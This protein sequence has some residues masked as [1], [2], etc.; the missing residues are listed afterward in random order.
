MAVP[1]SQ[2]HWPIAVGRTVVLADGGRANVR[3]LDRGDVG[4]VYAVFDGLS[5]SSRRQRFAGAKPSLSAREAERLAAV[6]H[7]NHE[8]FVAA[9]PTTRRPVAEA[10]LVRDPA[11]L[12]AGE[13]AFAVADDWQGRGLGT[14][15]AEIL[16]RRARELGITRLRASMLAEN[17]RSLALMRR[18]GPVV[19]RRYAAGELEVEVALD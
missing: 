10:H 8:A 6:D 12:A 17:A 19:A 11:D 4:S 15:L 1:G 16:A 14:R 5:A 7:E 2:L 18:M 9:D 13:V 3:T